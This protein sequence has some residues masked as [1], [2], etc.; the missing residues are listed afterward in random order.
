LWMRRCIV[1]TFASTE[2]CIWVLTDSEAYQ[3]GC[4]PGRRG[5]TAGSESDSETPTSPR[6][7]LL[8]RST[9]TPALSPSRARRGARPGRGPGGG[10]AGSVRVA[11][12]GG[13]AEPTLISPR[14]GSV[15]E[16]WRRGPRGPRAALPACRL[17]QSR[18]PARGGGGTPPPGRRNGPSAQRA[19][20]RRIREKSEQ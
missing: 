8:R 2:K 5:P 4:G 18:C 15:T 10:D 1:A 12:S 7:R 19:T 16:P 14:P 11:A 3:R 6:L 20:V 9:R 13:D 17:R